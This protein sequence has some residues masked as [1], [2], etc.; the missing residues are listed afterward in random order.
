MCKLSSDRFAK[1]VHEDEEVGNVNDSIAVEV[2]FWIEVFLSAL[3]SKCFDKEQKVC[4][5]DLSIAIKISRDKGRILHLEPDNFIKVR[6]KDVFCLVPYIH[7]GKSPRS[8][9]TANGQ[10]DPFMVGLIGSWIASKIDFVIIIIE[11]FKAVRY[12]IGVA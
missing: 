4:D 5:I 2:V 8:G 9:N 6:P 1:G 12:T 7:F 10:D 3:G 11:M